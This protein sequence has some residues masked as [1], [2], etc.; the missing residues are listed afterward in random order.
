MSYR[1]SKCAII[2]KLPP[3]DGRWVF[4]F[5]LL[6][7]GISVHIYWFSG[8][9]LQLSFPTL[10]PI[11]FWCWD[12]WFWNAYWFQKKFLQKMADFFWATCFNFVW[13]LRWLTSNLK[14]RHYFADLWNRGLS[15]WTQPTFSPFCLAAVGTA[16][17]LNR[18]E[19]S[20][21]LGAL[22]IFLHFS[23]TDN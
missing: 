22:N 18:A 15:S 8:Q 1:E 21:Y 2:I 7:S 4:E 13:V 12:L 11:F 14:D 3:T 23:Y 9:I 16:V 20:H 5:V 10:M 6:W 17:I 19:T